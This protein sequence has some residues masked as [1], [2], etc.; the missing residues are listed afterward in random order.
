MINKESHRLTQLINNILDF[1][2]IESG[3]KT[4]HFERCDVREVVCETLKTFGVR[5]RQSGFNI[6]L[7]GADIPLPPARIDAGAVAQS[8]SNLLDNA[9]K[10]SNGKTD[11][12]VTLRRDGDWIV[13]AVADQGIGIARD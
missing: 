12:T 10:Y 11:V 3:R 7:E 2:S 5:L 13:V 6:H 4:Y 8:L 1:A 9:V